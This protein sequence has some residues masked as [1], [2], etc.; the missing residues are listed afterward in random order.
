MYR[1][2]CAYL[3]AKKTRTALICM[4]LH[5]YRIDCGTVR[6]SNL[7]VCYV[8]SCTEDLGSF[9][10]KRQ[11]CSGIPSGQT[12]SRPH[13]TQ[14]Q[15]WRG[16]CVEL[17]EG[18][19]RNADSCGLVK[20]SL[21]EKN[22]SNATAT[23]YVNETTKKVRRVLD[24]NTCK[25]TTSIWSRRFVTFKSSDCKY[26]LVNWQLFWPWPVLVNYIWNK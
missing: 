24:R 15:V 22:L 20:S 10:T 8:V 14:Q 6:Q 2:T 9:P 25:F 13:R 21:E 19:T 12:Y 18:G 26:S 11:L 1:G 3:S 4:H 16:L 5:A 17:S 7:S 23:A